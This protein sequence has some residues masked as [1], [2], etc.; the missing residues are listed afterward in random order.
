MAKKYGTGDFHKICVR[1]RGKIE[2]TLEYKNLTKKEK[3][4]QKY[5]RNKRKTNYKCE[6]CGVNY[7][8][9]KQTNYIFFNY[10]RKNKP[11]RLVCY[12][13]QKAN[14]PIGLPTF[15][16][17]SNIKINE[18]RRQEELE[19]KELRIKEREIKNNYKQR[20]EE[21]YKASMSLKAEKRGE[22]LKNKIDNLY[23][24]FITDGVDN[25]GDRIMVYEIGNGDVNFSGEQFNWI[26]QR[27]KL[28]YELLPIDTVKKII[29]KLRDLKK[30]EKANNLYELIIKN[31]EEE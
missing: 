1:R 14:F 26:G 13:C 28:K 30:K 22:M 29:E 24:N 17:M 20:G 10:K 3:A 9:E 27:I 8:S 16:M 21:L 15:K 25:N 23:Y 19:K 12:N 4:I 5:R 6:V 7:L 2:N 11:F 18:K 31:R